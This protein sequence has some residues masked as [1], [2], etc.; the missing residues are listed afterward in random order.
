MLNFLNFVKI[1]YACENAERYVLNHFIFN[2]NVLNQTRDIL[3]IYDPEWTSIRYPIWLSMIKNGIQN[4]PY[5]EKNRSRKIDFA[6]VSEHCASSG[7]KHSIWPLLKGG[8]LH[9]NKSSH[10]K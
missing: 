3:C 10:Y 1:T 8:G 5:L 6:Y 9:G 7:T 2:R 4:R